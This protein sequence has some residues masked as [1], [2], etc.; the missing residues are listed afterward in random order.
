MVKYVQNIKILSYVIYMSVRNI[1][2]NHKFED[3]ILKLDHYIE[4]YDH[5]FLEYKRKSET[6]CINILEIGVLGGGSIELWNEYFNGN[7]FI[8]ALDINEKCMKFQKKY[9]NVKIFI[10]D[11]ENKEFLNSII[12]QI[13]KLDIIIDDGGHKMNQQINSFEV[14]YTHLDYSGTYLCEDCHT[15]YWKKWDGGSENS[16]IEYTK[17]LIDNLNVLHTLSSGASRAWRNKNLSPEFAKDT[18]CITYYDSVVIIKKRH[19][20]KEDLEMKTISK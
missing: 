12:S 15:S 10:G 3:K 4:I 20:R 18:L 11:Q 5:H 14:L 13:P 16:F 17:K 9:N 6:C 8:Y 19:N 7:C 2:D 1:I